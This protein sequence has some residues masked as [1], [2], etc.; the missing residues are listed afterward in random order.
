MPTVTEPRARWM[1]VLLLLPCAAFICVPLYNR[2]TPTLCG[3]PFFYWYQLAW[4]VL[5]AVAVGI[6]YRAERPRRPR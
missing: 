6:V 3:V 4:V 1:R 5:S 2:V